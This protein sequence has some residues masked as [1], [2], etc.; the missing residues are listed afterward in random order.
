[1]GSRWESTTH[2]PMGRR[3]ELTVGRRVRATVG[4]N[5]FLVQNSHE[6]LLTNQGKDAQAEEGEDHHVHQL[7]HRTQQ[8]P[9]N[10][11]QT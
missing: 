2:K 11:L 4:L 3:R 5:T 6:E 9:N 8:S 1:M 7:L 10:N